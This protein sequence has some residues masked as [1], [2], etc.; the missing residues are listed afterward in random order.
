[1]APVKWDTPR[2]DFVANVTQDLQGSSAA[3]VHVS[4]SKV[5][6]VEGMKVVDPPSPFL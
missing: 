1:M 4:S 2:K 5:D 3:K 6:Q